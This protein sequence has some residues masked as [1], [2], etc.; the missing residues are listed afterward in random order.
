MQTDQ[1]GPFASVGCVGPL[2]MPSVWLFSI[3]A[4]PHRVT[5]ISDAQVVQT[6][7]RNARPVYRT[8]LYPNWRFGFYI[9]CTLI[10]EF[11]ITETDQLLFL[12]SI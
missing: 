6:T 7:D 8:M 10:H 12:N 1:D 2:E 3:G 5:T 9:C 11:I 4:T